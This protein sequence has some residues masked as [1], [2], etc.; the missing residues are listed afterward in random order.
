MF[1]SSAGASSS[2]FSQTQIF[3]LMK[4]EFA[5]ARR[6]GYPLACVVVQV[7]RL[8]SL[9]DLHGA[10][11]RD[12][13]RSALVQIV[14]ERARDSDHLGLLADDRYVLLLPHTKAAGACVLAERVRKTFGEL[15]VRVRGNALLLGLSCGVASAEGDETLFFDSL[16]SQA[17]VAADWSREAGGNQTT[18]FS[19]D[20]F[21]QERKEILAWQ[22]REA[23]DAE[24]LGP[25]PASEPPAG[26]DPP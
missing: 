17:E 5:R 25:T 8:Q 23:E 22:S 15:D 16:L 18:V 3:H 14:A 7:D 24:E 19:R 9:I 20:R 10:E 21:K 4:T 2:P 12:A 11:L 6:Y 13:V 1:R 26:R